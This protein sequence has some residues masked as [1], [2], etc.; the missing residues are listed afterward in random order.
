M[1][2]EL[3][4]I[5]RRHPSK[6]DREPHAPDVYEILAGFEGRL[7]GFERGQAE[8]LERVER[9]FASGKHETIKV[10]AGVVVAA[11]GVIGGQRA[12]TPNPPPEV[13]NVP[14]RSA[15]D[16]RLDLCRPMAPGPSREECFAR[17]TAETDH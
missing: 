5:P 7:D 6:P 10:I 16:V 9:G 15:L 14:T 11:L 8:L 17:V 2:R 3:P 1:S 12:L 4:G 13:H